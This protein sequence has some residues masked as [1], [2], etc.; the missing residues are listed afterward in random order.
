MD[1]VLDILDSIEEIRE[2]ADKNP[3]RYPVDYVFRLCQSIVAYAFGYENRNEWT[4]R[5]LE[6]PESRYHQRNYDE[7]GNLIL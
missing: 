7:N 5:L 6:L 1:K 4:D 3:E 2:K